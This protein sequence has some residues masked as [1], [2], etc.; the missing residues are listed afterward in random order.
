MNFL[1]LQR[2]FEAILRLIEGTR[3][4]IRV[5]FLVRADT[6]GQRVMPKFIFIKKNFELTNER[7]SPNVY[8]YV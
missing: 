7:N 2:A 4:L 1:P 5:D 3:G 6:C 8:I